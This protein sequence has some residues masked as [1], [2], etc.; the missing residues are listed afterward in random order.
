MFRIVT[1]RR[2]WKARGFFRLSSV[3]AGRRNAA[4]LRLGAQRSGGGKA[5]HEPIHSSLSWLGGA[6][7][8]P[9][10]MPCAKGTMAHT[11]RLASW[12]AGT[13]ASFEAYS[14]GTFPPGWRLFLRYSCRDV[15]LPKAVDWLPVPS[16]VEIADT[17]VQRGNVF[18]RNPSLRNPYVIQLFKVLKRVYHIDRKNARC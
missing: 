6:K 1:L 13:P 4:W 14:R 5:R 3:V 16:Y 7:P 2:R 11:L 12:E 18:T 9:A 15:T 17:L 10:S 8:V